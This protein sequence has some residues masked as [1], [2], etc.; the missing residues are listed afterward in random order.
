MVSLC[1]DGRFDEARPIHDRMSELYKLLFADGNPAGIKAALHCKG[2]VEN[3]L[4]LPL[5]PATAPTTERI[6]E[7]ISSLEAHPI[8]TEP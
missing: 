7:I 3:V 6:A 1:L 4:R 8:L 5:L 2:L